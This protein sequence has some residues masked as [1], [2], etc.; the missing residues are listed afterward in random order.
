MD[1]Q[2]VIDEIKSRTDIVDL[3]SGYIELKKAGQNFKAL[4]PFHSEKTPSFTVSPEKQIFHCF[5]CNTGGDII[6]FVMKN[7]GL[8]FIEAVKTLADRAGVDVAISGQGRSDRSRSLKK[9]LQSIH[10]EALTYYQEMLQKNTEA[11]GYLLKR[12]LTEDT[13]KYFQLG[14]APAGSNTLFNL[15]SKRGYLESDI[16][17]SGLC[18]LTESGKK[19]TF[20][21][22]VIFPIFNIQGE[23]IAFGG[24]LIGETG[25]G[26][27]YLN[28]PETMLF[29]KSSV[30]FGLNLAK[31]TIQKK[32]YVLV[33]EGYLDV[34]TSHQFGLKNSVAPL[35][36]ALTEEHAR[37]L[38]PLTKKVLLVFDADEAGI[39]AS[40]RALSIL[41]ENDFLAKVLLLPQGDD[42]DTFLMKNGRKAFEELFADVKGLVDFYLSLS[43]ERVDIVRELIFIISRIQ[44]AIMRGELIREAAEKTGLSE[45]FLREELNLTKKTPGRETLKQQKAVSLSPE[46]LLLGLYLS[47]PGYAPM[48]QKELSPSDILDSRVRSIFEVL[49][50]QSEGTE[51][52]TR[53]S[54]EDLSLVTEATIQLDIDKDEIE[55][56]VI[57][58]IKHIRG[59]KLRRR[60][61]DI[62]IEIRIAEKR[63][64][65]DM[66][67]KLQSQMGLLLSEGK[68]EGIL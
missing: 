18:K 25:F 65:D 8:S 49:F 44:N 35:G 58:C 2:P 48:I 5:G 50:A 16:L 68:D 1:L 41:Y 52:S 21:K 15:L 11:I 17:S 45:Q 63:S 20:R 30:L 66:V 7:D 56:N 42:P 47:Y 24:R 53:F 9:T 6:S 60:L 27:K 31:A 46:M 51:T 23:I 12:G 13:M 28:S 14:L 59:Q 33:M 22:R 57:D 3:L 54:D 37:K 39:K 38:K 43:G 55:Q 4:C 26:P 32:G 64:E 34:I 40:R 67:L 19:D 10:H 62:E 36:T 29:R 61:K